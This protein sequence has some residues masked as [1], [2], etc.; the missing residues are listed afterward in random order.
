L[1][2]ENSRKDTEISGCGVQMG[3][4]RRARNISV[5][6]GAELE[7]DCVTQPILPRVSNCLLPSM[8]AKLYVLPRIA[9]HVRS[10][11]EGF[12]YV[13]MELQKFKV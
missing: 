1:R 10:R 5:V 12:L 4:L 6:I 2:L 7:S 3:E 8:I 9:I 11:S 13:D